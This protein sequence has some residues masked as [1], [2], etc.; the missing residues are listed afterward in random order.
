L[1]KLTISG[2]LYGAFLAVIL[3]LLL[4]VSL[5]IFKD[6]EK[7]SETENEITRLH[8]SMEKLSAE[9]EQLNS[10]NTAL[11]AE[12]DLLKTENNQIQSK[13]DEMSEAVKEKDSVILTLE[14]EKKELSESLSSAR[15]KSEL[16]VHQGLVRA[17]DIDASLVIDLRYATDDNFTG[18]DELLPIKGL[19]SPQATILSLS[20]YGDGSELAGK[21]DR[22]EVL[23]YLNIKLSP[24]GHYAL[25]LV[26]DK[27]T[28]SFLMM[29]METL[30][31][32][33]VQSPPGTASMRAGNGVPPSNAYPSGYNWFEGNKVVIL[34]EDGLKLYEFAY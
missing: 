8:E 33:S 9:Y 5:Q 13:L 22:G 29:D 18:Y 19:D 21:I 32:R 20:A 28:Y 11:R 7:Y 31:L 24:D 30:T 14:E 3:I 15:N 1:K 12:N 6:N 23:Q 4:A 34:T 10:Q 2:K 27:K 26:T 25:L 17:L 16:F